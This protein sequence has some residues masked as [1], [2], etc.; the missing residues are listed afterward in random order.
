ME[1]EEYKAMVVAMVRDR[2]APFPQDEVS[3]YVA[4]DEV[5]QAIRLEYGEEKRY[6]QEGKKEKMDGNSVAY[7]L[8]MMF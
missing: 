1:Y 4:S 7:G 2:L 5:E 3:A 6:I 8:M